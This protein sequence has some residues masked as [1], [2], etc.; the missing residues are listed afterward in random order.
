MLRRF[1]IIIL[2]IFFFLVTVQGAERKILV[3]SLT[4]NSNNL[5]LS[6]HIDG[7]ISNNTIQ[8]LERGLTSE[9]L[10][11]IRLWKSKK[12]F[13]AI[14][15]EVFISIKLYYDNWEDKFRIITDTE[16]RLTTQV[17]TVR[18]FCSQVNNF[19]LIDISELE[20]NNKYYISIETTFKPVSAET[21]QDL[22]DWLSGNTNSEKKE[23]P[24]QGGQ[25]KIFGVLLNAM[26]FGDKVLSYKSKDFIIQEDKTIRFLE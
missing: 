24:K 8:G 13:S 25:N 26:G 6:Y 1:Y 14:S 17:E 20:S 10:H 3:D 16:N 12:L 15:S 5:V 4:V 7:L 23:K 18:E 9:V 2:V 19:P 22:S 11:H 21:Y